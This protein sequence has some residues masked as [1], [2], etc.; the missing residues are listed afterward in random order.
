MG[1]KVKI[2]EKMRIDAQIYMYLYK[3]CFYNEENQKK[4]QKYI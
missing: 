4:L 1:N 3:I 2:I